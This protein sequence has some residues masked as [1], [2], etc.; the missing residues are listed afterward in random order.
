MK[1]FLWFSPTPEFS[2]REPKWDIGKNYCTICGREI[3]TE[4]YRTIHVVGGGSQVLH[5]SDEQAYNVASP[6]EMGFMPIGNDCARKLGI[7][8]THPATS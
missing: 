2:R 7:D 1:D 4:S 3:K 5:P 8:W 6:G